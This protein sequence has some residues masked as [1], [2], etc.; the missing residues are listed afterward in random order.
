MIVWVLK[1]V[2]IPSGSRQNSKDWAEYEKAKKYM[3][4]HYSLG[5]K[6]YKTCLNII[7]DCI[8]V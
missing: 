8:G 1:M 7:A 5:P 4:D 2:V 6:E 3:T